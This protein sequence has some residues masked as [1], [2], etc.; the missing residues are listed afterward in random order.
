VSGR[1]S[2]LF[3]RAAPLPVVLPLVTSVVLAGCGVVWYRAHNVRIPLLTTV[4][5][6]DDGTR[7][8]GYSPGVAAPSLYPGTRVLRSDSPSAQEGAR[9]QR[10]WLESK[11][12]PGGSGP[13][14]DMVADALLDMHTLILKN[15]ASLA[16]WPQAWRYVWP[17]DTSF[18]AAALSRSGHPADALAVMRF[19]QSVV[20]ASGVFQARYLP[21]GSGVPDDRGEESDGTGLIL[22]A[23][24]QLVR[25]APTATARAAVLS[26]LRPL[27][28]RTA[29]AAL[30][31]TAP[32]RS[33]ASLPPAS[34]DYWEV[35]DERLSLGTVAP[36][37]A[38][39]SAAA[40]LYADLGVAVSAG[41]CRTR[42]R[43][44]YRAIEN[45]YGAQGYPRYLG[46]DARDASLAFLLPPFTQ[47]VDPHVLQA[48]RQA[49][50]D[51]RQ[52]AGGLSPGAGWKDDGVSWTPETALF[53]L[54]AASTGDRQLARRWLDWL[55]GHRTPFGALPEKVLSNA[56]PAGPAPLSFAAGLTVLAVSELA[57]TGLA[58]PS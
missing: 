41:Q 30:R 5:A 48:W 11:P 34:Q 4:V 24:D 35:H 26:T 22:W 44:L 18:V 58:P 57:A 12:L 8:V 52:P 14:R 23:I 49:A 19:L 38:G 51:M 50:V 31:L 55:D 15:G 40:H 21:D 6:V 7:L 2:R 37:A 54:T 43:D 20:P 9:R 53:A 25:D 32:G 47:V 16:G 46:D 13:Y 27:I 42:A 1:R 45:T 29:T 56:A 28:D 17:R 36:L 33:G 10:E 3:L 39:L